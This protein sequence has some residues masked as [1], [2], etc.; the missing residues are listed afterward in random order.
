MTSVIAGVVDEDI[1]GGEFLEHRAHHAFK[2]GSV[3]KIAVRVTGAGR[4]AASIL[5]ASVLA[6]NLEISKK[7]TREL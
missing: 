3:R 1:D 6:A 7:I 2:C 5:P 4:P